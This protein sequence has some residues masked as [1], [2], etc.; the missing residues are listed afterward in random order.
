MA[1]P[2]PDSLSALENQAIANAQ[3]TDDRARK[4]LQ[5]LRNEL[6]M[7][8]SVSASILTRSSIFAIAECDASTGEVMELLTLQ[9]ALQKYSEISDDLQ[10]EVYSQG[11]SSAHEISSSSALSL[12]SHCY[13]ARC[14]DLLNTMRKH[15]FEM[16]PQLLLQHVEIRLGNN[17]YLAFPCIADF[18]VKT[19]SEMLHTVG[20]EHVVQNDISRNTNPTVE[21][22]LDGLE[23]RL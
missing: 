21:K 13:K 9:N 19:I 6:L 7:E 20:T 8:A 10:K 22:G 5:A 3:I 2:S 1:I 18:K 23:R 17:A 12:I 16:R 15:N 11:I 14:L 4:I